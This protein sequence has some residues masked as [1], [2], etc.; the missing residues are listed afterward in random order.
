EPSEYRGWL[1]LWAP[2]GLKFAE[3]RDGAVQTGPLERQLRE[4]IISR[5]IDLV[6]IDPFIKAH[7][8]PE[9]DNGLI[10]A[11]AVL[12]VRLALDLNIAIDVLHHE[13]KGAVREPGNA[14]R[15]RGASALRDAGRLI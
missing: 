8:V 12:L 15:G 6:L 11:V 5:N 10:D 3:F 4:F 9:N 2:V 14:D 7:S 1:Y 13:R